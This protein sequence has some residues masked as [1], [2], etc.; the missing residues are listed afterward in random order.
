MLSNEINAIRKIRTELRESELIN[1]HAQYMRF[2]SSLIKGGDRDKAIEKLN[3]MKHDWREHL[4]KCAGI[5]PP[6]L[7]YKGQ[8]IRRH[9]S[10]YS[11][12]EWVLE[13]S[14]GLQIS[15]IVL[16]PEF[17]TKPHAN[18]LLIPP[19]GERTG[20]GSRKEDTAERYGSLIADAGY[21]VIIPDLPTLVSVSISSVKRLILLGKT[22][23]GEIARELMALTTF[24][25]NQDKFSELPTAVMG[26]GISGW[27]GLVYSALDERVSGAFVSMPSRMTI[28]GYIPGMFRKFTFISVGILVSPRVLA[29]SSSLDKYLEVEGDIIKAAYEVE[30]AKEMYKR[31][32]LSCPDDLVKWFVEEGSLW[33]QN[34][35]YRHS[36]KSV[37][38]IKPM[39]ITESP[40]TPIKIK[41]A[42]SGSEWENMRE[43]L[44]NGL[45]S[46]LGINLQR[47]EVEGLI[48][49]KWEEDNIIYERINCKS[50]KYAKVPALMVKSCERKRPVV[51]CIPGSSHSKDEMVDVI[52][53]DLVKI[54]FHAFIVDPKPSRFSRIA[55]DEFMDGKPMLGQM[56]LDVIASI[57]YLQT[58]DDVD[59][60]SIGCFGISMGGTLTWLAAA[61]DERIKVVVLALC[62]STYEKLIGSVR[63][64]S[65]DGSFLSFLDSHGE[66]YFVPGIL[67]LGEQ[68]AFIATIAPR[69]LLL[70][71]TTKDNCFPFDGARE[72]YEN[73]AH[74]YRLMGAKDK[75]AFE[76]ADA[77]HAFTDELRIATMR[78]FSMWL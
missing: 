47:N 62:F 76:Y 46:L 20:L 22:F 63:D 6:P 68:D 10:R 35:L 3:Q 73:V 59:S 64:D 40:Q 61:I 19:L 16:S 44:R 70:L 51:I 17:V 24:L 9:P 58:R 65:V 30:G 18:I 21:R 54:G 55:M 74:I 50:E 7:P 29:I 4:S 66:Y 31:L 27:A 48:E 15:F 5:F 43:K 38:D 12:S 75:V 39:F 45:I 49:Q 1:R 36:L 11:T 13:L 57:D 33:A 34:S 41:S 23:I 42:K 78:W 53:K 25:A 28:H 37:R 77:P 69:P 26:W 8:L 32:A 71:A 56:A 52:G 14:D 72:V 60:N 2:L 67:C